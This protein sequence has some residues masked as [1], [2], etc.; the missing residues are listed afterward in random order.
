MYCSNSRIPLLN[1]L[2]GVFYYDKSLLEFRV[3]FGTF[4]NEMLSCVI[5]V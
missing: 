3:A 2:S 5:V 1:I 4:Q